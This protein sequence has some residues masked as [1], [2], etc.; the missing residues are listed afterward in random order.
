[1]DWL[2]LLKAFHVLGFIIWFAGLFGLSVVLIHHKKAL[3]AGGGETAYPHLTTLQRKLY[4][5][6][7]NPGMMLAWTAGL[8]MLGL[9]IGTESVPNYLS[10][11]VGTPGWMHAKLLFLVILL[12]LHLYSKRFIGALEQGGEKLS[13][14]RIRF[15]VGAMIWLMVAIVFLASLGNRGLLNYM[16]WG[17]GLAV[18]VGVLRFLLYRK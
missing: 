4:R 10:A 14:N 13:L 15:V 17:I 6:I 9:G 3:L 5:A 18:F 16:Y 8:I 11:D 7:A 1:M 12:G 2:Y